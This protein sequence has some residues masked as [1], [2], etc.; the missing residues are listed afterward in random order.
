ME[1][2]IFFALLAPIAV[3]FGAVVFVIAYICGEIPCLEHELVPDEK[4]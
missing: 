1:I 2:W 3:I 4:V